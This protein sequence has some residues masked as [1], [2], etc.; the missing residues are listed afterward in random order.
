MP[1]FEQKIQHCYHNQFFV[2]KDMGKNNFHRSCLERITLSWFVTTLSSAKTKHLLGILI[3]RHFDAVCFYGAHSFSRGN[4]A[5]DLKHAQSFCRCVGI[6][7][8]ALFSVWDRELFA[9][10]IAGA[11]LVDHYF[12]FRSL[13]C[14]LSFLNCHLSAH[15]KLFMQVHTLWKKMKETNWWRKHRSFGVSLPVYITLSG[16]L[17]PVLVLW[18]SMRQNDY[19]YCPLCFLS[20]PDLFS[21]CSWYHQCNALYIVTQKEEVSGLQ[22][23]QR[24]K[25]IN[26]ENLWNGF[27]FRIAIINIGPI[28]G[29]RM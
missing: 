22:L 9:G 10:E 8:T 17:L 4:H 12:Y 18:S 15:F 24:L 28:W 3:C 5:S 27:R 19:F 7:V 11:V 2:T 26:F 1:D 6:I 25:L 20:C 23:I 14:H 13:N 29:E 21:G 16:Q